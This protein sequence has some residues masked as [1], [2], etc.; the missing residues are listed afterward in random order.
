MHVFGFPESTKTSDEELSA[1]AESAK[2]LDDGLSGFPKVQKLWKMGLRDSRKYKI[3]GRWAFGFPESTKS[4]DDGPSG[5]PKAGLLRTMWHCQ[6]TTTHS[7]SEM[8]A[9]NLLLTNV[10][11]AS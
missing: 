1:N 4:L 2:T 7:F 3:F 8:N 5:F 9:C 10:L 11:Y 6:S